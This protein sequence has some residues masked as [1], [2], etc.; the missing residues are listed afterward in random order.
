M[1]VWMKLLH[2]VT[3]FWFIGGFIGRS[4]TMNYAR[5]ATDIKT[6]ASLA[7]LGHIFD[8][9]MVIP[10][11]M[12]VLGFGLIT[13]WLQRW[14]LIGSSPAYWLLISTILYLSAY[15]IIV[16]VFIPRGK[17][18]RAALEDAQAQGQITAALKAAFDDRAVFL[19]HIYEYVTTGIIVMLMVTKPF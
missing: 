3:A 6:V 10:G 16:K 12:A 1:A 15:P 7:Q 4:T 19:S 5:R 18:F 2:V 8:K 17:I 9:W 11:S 14:T 13:A